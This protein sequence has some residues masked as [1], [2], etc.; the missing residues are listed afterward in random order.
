[1]VT[2]YK[3]KVIIFTSFTSYLNLLEEKLKDTP[4]TF[5]ESQDSI[6]SRTRKIN[7]WKNK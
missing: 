1:M 3:E 4:L 2:M 5:I 7:K 6:I